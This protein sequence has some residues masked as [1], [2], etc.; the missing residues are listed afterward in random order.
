MNYMVENFMGFKRFERRLSANYFPHAYGK[1]VNIG[2]IGIG[3]A[4]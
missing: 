2:F 1:T 3:L 4:L